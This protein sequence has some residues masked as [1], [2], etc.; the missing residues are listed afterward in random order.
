MASAETSIKTPLRLHETEV[1][2]EWVDYN[3]HMSEAFYV[4][5]FGHTTDALL[6]YVGM[7]A[8]YRERSQCSLY[9]LEAHISY[10]REAREA[11]PLRITTQLLDVDHKRVHVFHCMY[12][13]GDGGLLATGELMLLH[14][15]NTEPTGPRS[16]PFPEEVSVRLQEIEAAHDSLPRPEQAGRSIGIRR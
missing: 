15:D 9:T 14:V 12:H 5:V 10:L 16:A 2:P 1:K 13:A 4:L 6:D 11:E 7:N 8:D 3:G